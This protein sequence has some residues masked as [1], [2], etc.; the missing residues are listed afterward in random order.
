MI[1]FLKSR[2][3]YANLLCIDQVLLNA[4]IQWGFKYFLFSIL[5][6]KCYREKQWGI[7]YGPQRI[8]DNDKSNWNQ[9]PDQ[10]YSSCCCLLIVRLLC[11]PRDL[12]ACYVLELR[13]HQWLLLLLLLLLLLFLLSLLCALLHC[14]LLII[15]LYCAWEHSDSSH[16]SVHGL[17]D[18]QAITTLCV[19]LCWRG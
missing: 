6:A 11:L 3:G 8:Q 2:T 15:P 12:L 16:G 13:A 10:I 14:T 5:H 1:T 17:A 4:L 9:V 18:G 7:Q 19:L